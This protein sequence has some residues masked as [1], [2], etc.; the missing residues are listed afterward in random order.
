MKHCIAQI[1]N[2][3]EKG[4]DEKSEDGRPLPGDG[5]ELLPPPRCD[6]GDV[7]A[8]NEGER[9]QSEERVEIS[10]HTLEKPGKASL[11]GEFMTYI[12]LYHLFCTGF[13]TSL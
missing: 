2:I 11:T 1:N 7:E 6:E 12:S 5:K 10:H 9:D 3:K 8:E 13:I 4:I